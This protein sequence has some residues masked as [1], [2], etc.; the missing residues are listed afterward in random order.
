MNRLRILGFLLSVGI[1]PA[2]GM[3]EDQLYTGD[4]G[5]TAPGNVK[6]QLFYNTLFDAGIEVTGGSLTFGLRENVDARAGYGYL[7][8][9]QGPSTQIG[10]NI[11]V[12][13]RFVGTGKMGTSFAASGLY[14]NN[15]SV[16]TGER[17]DDIGALLIG[18]YVT[19]EVV[20]LANLG[21]VWAGGPDSD[22]QYTAFAVAKPTTE[23]VLLALEYL[24]ISPIGESRTA[25]QRGQYVAG[26]VYT[27][28]ERTKYSLQV[29]YLPG[30]IQDSHWAATLG[31]SRLLR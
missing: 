23:Q 22:L 28:D 2:F 20:L 27:A 17:K 18:E 11:G 4:A 19:R 12:K 14:A 16:V 5:T 7:W 13:W 3:G 24:Q 26:I 31:Y 29:G 1:A 9:D 6:F 10:P 21:R 8:N 30:A 15:T 25:R